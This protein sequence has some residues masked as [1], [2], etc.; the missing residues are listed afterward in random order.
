MVRRGQILRPG[1]VIAINPDRAKSGIQRALNIIN[2]MIT[3][4]EDLRRIDGEAIRQL[5]KDLRIRFRYFQL[6]GAQRVLDQMTQTD[7]FDTGISIAD[8][9]QA[10]A[11]A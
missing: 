11:P 1:I 9:A 4:V 3:N 5:M 7:S 6:R 2:R 10:K 8:R